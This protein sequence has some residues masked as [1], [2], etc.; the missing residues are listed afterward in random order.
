LRRTNWPRGQ[1]ALTSSRVVLPRVV[2]HR[3]VPYR[4]RGPQTNWF[5][6]HLRDLA[7]KLVPSPVEKCVGGGPMIEARNVSKRRGGR[8]VV[9]DVSF[10]VA[11]SEVVALVGANGAG[12]STLLAIV[13]GSLAPDRGWVANN[14]ATSGR[15]RQLGYVPEAADPPGHLTG[16]ELLALAAALRD[17]ATKGRAT[18]GGNG[19]APLD[20]ATRAR[21]GVDALA[22]QRIERMSLGQRRRVCLAAALVG[23]PSALVLDEPDNGLDADGLDALV[24]I[25]S[26]ATARNAA[27]L[28]ATHDP[29]VRSRLGARELHLDG[30]RLVGQ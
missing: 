16:G 18:K 2:T 25:I 20:D 28:V 27:I 7:L 24:E 4:L 22:G 1:F 19:A 21:L 17:G 13:A 10:T 9:D 8:L 26:A 15:R 6:N 30:G 3:F 29:A 11:G 12:K 14:G 5:Q 23:A